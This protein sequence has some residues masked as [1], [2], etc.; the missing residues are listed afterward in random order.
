MTR[1]RASGRASGRSDDLHGGA[2]ETE[3]DGAGGDPEALTAANATPD[4][5]RGRDPM[6]KETGCRPSHF[7]KQW[8]GARGAGGG[9]ASPN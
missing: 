5:F 7:L 3:V 2:V 8:G 6:L 1:R 9:L 4:L